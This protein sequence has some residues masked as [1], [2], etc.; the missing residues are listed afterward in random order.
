MPTCTLCGARKRA[1]AFPPARGR[2]RACIRAGEHALIEASR[3]WI[4]G[5]ARR[6]RR[7]AGKVVDRAAAFA[8]DKPDHRRMTRGGPPHHYYWLRH[9]A[10]MAYGGYRCACCG[11][12][13]PMFLTLDHVN[14]DGARDR[15]RFGT[16]SSIPILLRLRRRG[17]PPGMQVLCSNCNHGRHRNGGTC[18]HRKN[19][20][21]RR[22]RKRTARGKGRC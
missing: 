17:Y 20:R 14:N 18:P 19:G 21:R 11:E 2:C 1:S 8:A 4:D 10:I 7:S 22:V 6:W 3:R 15:R 5:F 16:L 13:E 9:Q 12:G